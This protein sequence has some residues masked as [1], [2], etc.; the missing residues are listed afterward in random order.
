MHMNSNYYILGYFYKIIEIVS[1][2][3]MVEYMN[4]VT[5]SDFYFSIFPYHPF[6][7]RLYNIIC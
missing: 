6:K 2:H 4:D 1:Y 7:A 5:G 3:F